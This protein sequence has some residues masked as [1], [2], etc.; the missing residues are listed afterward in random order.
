MNILYLHAH[1]MGRYNGLYG[2]AIQTPNLTAAA[3]SGTVFT[4][5]CCAAPTCSPSR[6]A[7][8]TGQY[9]HSNGLIGL[10][11]R[12]FSLAE[13]SHHLAAWL[14]QQGFHTVLSGHQHE[15]ADSYSLGY[16]EV[17]PPD[18]ERVAATDMLSQDRA[19]A[20]AAASFLQSR[21]NQPEQPF[22]LAVGFR[23]PHRPYLPHQTVNPDRVQPPHCLPNNRQTREDYADYIESVQEMDRSAGMVLDAL[24]K[25][26]HWQNTMV[27]LTTDHGIA[28]PH[29]KCNLYDTGIGVT[30]M[31]RIPGQEMPPLCDALVS[32]VDIYPTICDV[33]QL[34][35]PAWLQGQSLMPLFCG[36]ESIR[37]EIFAESTYHAA[38]EPMRCIRTMRH[39][40]IVR[41]D[42]DFS[43]FVLPNIDNGLSKRFLLVSGIGDVVRSRVELYDLHL[44]PAERNNLADDPDYESVRKQLQERL[45]LFLRESN[46]PILAGYV[47]KPTGARVN[48]KSGIHPEDENYE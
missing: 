46:D 1:D 48:Q 18:H 34:D 9:P 28:F 4:N 38:Y 5:A 2:Y 25:F 26:G 27:I 32:H 47:P 14:R 29:M 20:H 6:G 8:L 33:L 17:L 21:Q 22:F 7:L 12:G 31:L 16:S 23:L 43:K 10:T 35:R 36:T 15:A 13:P 44:D 40:L 3:Q 37:S 24:K 19:A 39:K 41:Y 11:H 42:D 30:L 45:D